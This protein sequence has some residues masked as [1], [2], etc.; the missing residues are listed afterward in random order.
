[1]S[2]VLVVTADV[3]RAQMAGPAMRAWHIA[4]H[5]SA[6]NDVRLVTTSPF[7]EVG[8]NGF[9]VYAA[10]P[11]ALA[12]A[13]AW[14]DVMVLQGYVT[15]HHPV[16][17]TSGKVIVFDVYDPLHV[18]TLALTHGTVSE[19]RDN[20]VRLSVDTMNGQLARAD[21]LMCAS[22]RQRD[23]F[24]GELCAL[25]RVNSLTYDDDPTLDRLISIVP[26]GLP[27][28]DPQRHRPALRGVVPGIGPDDDVIVWAGGVYDW[29]DPLTLVRAMALLAPRRPKARLF[30]MGMRHPNPDVPEM[31]VA[32]ATRAL[33]AELGLAG[34]HVFFNDGWVDYADRQD[35]LLDADIGVSLHHDNAETRYS[36]RT[37][38]LDYLWA[39]IPVV[40]TVG[41]MFAELV[42]AEGTG[43][44]V[45]AEDA[46]A[47]ADAIGGLLD[48]PALAAACRA[49]AAEVRPRFR[50]SQVLEPLAQFCRQ[51]RRAPDLV[52]GLS[53][54]SPPAAV[55]APGPAAEVAEAPASEPT[56][57]A[58]T[59]EAVQA[60]PVQPGTVRAATV[61]AEAMRAEA[62]PVP[63]PVE[64][65]GAE[66]A[67]PL[68]MGAAAAPRSTLGLAVYHYRH[69]GMGAVA[70]HTAAKTARWFSVWI[71]RD[72]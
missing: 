26:F 14:C 43:L 35:Y 19:A 58:P 63:V 49:R 38:Q 47:V 56:R 39:A 36:F 46:A 30:F 64:P 8:G 29:F 21:F 41:D 67:G 61:Q 15:L 52:A 45:P 57:A 4:A 28:D 12:E 6:G 18:E 69:G 13:E 17:A 59:L 1:M 33:A 48:D 20:H 10:G 11:E 37:R 70:R 23:L 51:P 32:T 22:S 71:V 34:T 53:A 42:Q 9:A 27:D 5:L 54:V 16:L 40:S 3:L 44:T 24:I 31:R 62:E 55:A 60:D 72:R 65:R 66:P 7:C 25:G 2:R 50:W 68:P